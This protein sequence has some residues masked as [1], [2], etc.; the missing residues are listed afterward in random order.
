M[1]KDRALHAWFKNF[2]D[3]NDLGVYVNTSV[4]D[5][6]VLPYMT[7]TYTTGSMGDLPVSSTVNMWFKTSSEAIPNDAAEKFRKYVEA[8]DRI[9]CDEGCIFVYPGQPWC[10]SQNDSTDKTVKLRY[11]NLTMDFCTE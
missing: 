7:Y 8:N 10:I 2:T 3:R 6:A 4:P 9:E 11:I 5:G 1:K